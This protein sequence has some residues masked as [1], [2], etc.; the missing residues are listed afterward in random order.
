MQNKKADILLISEGAYP[1][2]S[3]GVSAWVQ[4]LIKSLPHYSFGILFLGSQE[5]DYNEMKYQLP[6]NVAFLKKCYL[7]EKNHHED[8]SQDLSREQYKYINKLHSLFKQNKKMSKKRLS[9]LITQL[10]NTKTSI[11]EKQFLTSEKAWRFITNN[12]ERYCTTPSFIDYFWTVRS[13]HAPIWRLLDV[14]NDLP[15]TSLVHTVSTGYAGFLSALLHYRDK[16]PLLLT[17]HGIYTKERRLDLLQTELDQANS[18]SNED[19]DISYLRKLW[20]NFFDAI[21]LFCYN[22][23]DTIVSLYHGAR[24]KQHEFGAEIKKQ[25]VI[26]NG[27]DIKL[28]SQYRHSLLKNKKRLCL[29]GRVVPI[30]DIKTFIRAIKII[31]DSHSDIEAHI[32]GPLDEDKDYVKECEQLIKILEVEPYVKIIGKM[33]LTEVLPITDIM[34]LSSI[35]EGMPLVILEAFA[36]GIP[37]VTTDVGSCKELIDGSD[38][39]DRAIG[40]AGY[41]VNIRDPKALA[42]SINELLNPKAWKIASQNAIKRVET[43]YSLDTMIESYD[44]LYQKV[45]QWQE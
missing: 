35:S 44:Q 22:A 45:G 38:E 20:I 2:I 29:L 32:V 10:L 21:G 39:A 41:T 19:D 8:K 24:D 9:S 43:Y 37:A 33:P 17:E 12:Y 26:P 28:L 34:V 5:S 40:A 13:I 1:Y 23:S 31:S 16:T 30:K 14:V 25:I 18:D 27:I 7:F 3:G 36:A 15:K 6:D 4:V 11:K 42:Q